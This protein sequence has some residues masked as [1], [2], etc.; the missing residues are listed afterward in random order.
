VKAGEEALTQESMMGDET[1]YQWKM[2][3]PPSDNNESEDYP[4]TEK[5]LRFS[6]WQSAI[7]VPNM[8]TRLFDLKGRSVKEVP[9]KDYRV[10]I[11]K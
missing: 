4:G 6:K 2:L 9:R 7:G 5:I 1:A 11:K 3:I 10:I 8:S